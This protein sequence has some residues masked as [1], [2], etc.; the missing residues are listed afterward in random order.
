M[1]GDRPQFSHWF[2]AA[3]DDDHIAFGRLADKLGSPNMK[4]SY[5][6][7][8]HMLQCSTSS[9]LHETALAIPDGLSRPQVIEDDKGLVQRFPEIMPPIL[10]RALLM[11]GNP[12]IGNLDIVCNVICLLGAFAHSTGS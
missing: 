8:P 7:S 9:R 11:H 10:P 6:R 3:F 1:H 4:V 5:G 2:T 12:N